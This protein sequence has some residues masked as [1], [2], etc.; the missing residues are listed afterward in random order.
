[1]KG[2]VLDFNEATGTG[3]ISGEDGNRYSFEAGAVMSQV[4][5]RAGSKVDFQ[6]NE[7]GQADGIYVEFGSSAA[8]SKIVAALLA[9]FLGGLGIHKFYL[10]KNT[11]GIIMLA[12]FPARFHT[13]RHSDRD[14]QH[15]RLHRVHHLSGEVR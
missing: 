5:A 6:V 15:H 14:C 3:Q 1:M 13:A 9:F 2:T 10:G 11:A 12:V 7:S 4:A 8:K